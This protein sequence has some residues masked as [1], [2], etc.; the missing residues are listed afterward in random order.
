MFINT[1]S[2][3]RY[4]IRTYNANFVLVTGGEVIYTYTNPG[5][6]TFGTGPADVLTIFGASILNGA[7]YY[8]VYLDTVA[9]S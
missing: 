5:V 2:L 9:D 6:Y 8:K 7:T 4:K 3:I 1:S